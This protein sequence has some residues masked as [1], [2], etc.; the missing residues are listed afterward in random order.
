MLFVK[1]FAR[2]FSFAEVRAFPCASARKRR[3]QL[4]IYAA[5]RAVVINNKLSPLASGC[6]ARRRDRCAVAARR[7][8]LACPSASLTR[9]M[10]LRATCVRRVAVQ[11]VESAGRRWR[12]AAGADAAPEPLHRAPCARRRRALRARPPRH[13]RRIAHGVRNLRSASCLAARRIRGTALPRRGMNAPDF[14]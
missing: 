6:A 2:K 8:A 10:A 14:A 13:A 9:R 12:P 5:S 1:G 3:R 7:R 4:V 11:L